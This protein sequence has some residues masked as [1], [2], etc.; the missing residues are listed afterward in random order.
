MGLRGT[1]VRKGLP[2]L[3]GAL[4]CG[5]IL[6]GVAGAQQIAITVDDLPVHSVLPHG[7]TRIDVARRILRALRRTHV[8]PTYGFV[9]GVR[10]QQQAD[11][12]AVLAAWRGTG[13]LLANETWSHMDL[14]RVSLQQFEG[15]VLKNE[16]LLQLQMKGEDWHWFRFPDLAEGDTPEKKMGIR[17]FLAQHGYR[18]AAVT[19]NFNDWEWNEPYARCSD[20]H[21]R[22]AIGWLEASY[23][24]AAKEALRSDRKMSQQLYGREISYVLLLHLGAF[25]ARMLPRLLRMYRER[26]IEFVT[27]EDAEKDP[28]YRY[29]VNPKVLPGPDTLQGAM[30]EKH[31]QV[32]ARKDYSAKL[33]AMCR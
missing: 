15:D 20:R 7:E 10:V 14:N 22:R 5:A 1:R 3:M 11:T 26:G 6:A 17:P 16:A 30:A 4:V 29:D 2:G 27:L 8:P 33:E 13:D 9:N 24:R 25:D 12:V 28:F 23:L 31:L 19:M 21:E 18:I 32:P